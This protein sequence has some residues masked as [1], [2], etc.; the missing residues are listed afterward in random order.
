ASVARDRAEDGQALVISNHRGGRMSTEVAVSL[1]RG[2]GRTASAGAA[3]TALHA[4]VA[5]ARLKA[6]AGAR[7]HV[8]MLV[9]LDEESYG[10]VKISRRN[11]RAVRM[12]CMGR[13]KRP[14]YGVD[15]IWDQIY[16]RPNPFEV[17][18]YKF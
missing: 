6:S 9:Q 1:R 18:G 8:Y 14:I 11:G 3:S 12:I 2:Y 17:A 7:E 16:F 10:L 15:T 5:G 4:R 13:T